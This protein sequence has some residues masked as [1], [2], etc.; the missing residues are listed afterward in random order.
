MPLPGGASQG[1]DLVKSRLLIAR[2]RIECLDT[3]R[4]EIANVAGHDHELVNNRR[5]SDQSVDQKI[6]L[7]SMHQRR[8]DAKRASIDWQN[9]PSTRDLID[10]AFDLSG[11]F[12]ILLSGLLDARLQLAEG[13]SRQVK[14]LIGNALE[15]SDHGAVRPWTP[16][17]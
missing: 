8:P 7:T 3:Q 2:E 17:L 13:H 16:Q 11:L 15:P 12:R 14:I 4:R 5:G 9:V 10:P 1:H 6:V